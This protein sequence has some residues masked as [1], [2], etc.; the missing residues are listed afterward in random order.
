[1]KFPKPAVRYAD[2]SHKAYSRQQLET[3][4]QE[5]GYAVIYD[6]SLEDEVIVKIIGDY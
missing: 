5:L 6:D 1:M 4:L 3:L 2:D